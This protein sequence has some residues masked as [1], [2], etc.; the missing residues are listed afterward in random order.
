MNLL[1]NLIEQYLH[2]V[3]PSEYHIKLKDIFS[4][5]KDNQV[6]VKL[7]NDF[8]VHFS[9][10][11]KFEIHHINL[12]INQ[13]EF[14]FAI[15]TNNT[16][17]L[18]QYLYNKR[19]IY[20]EF[21]DY[22]LEKEL[23]KEQLEE[24]YKDKLTNFINSILY[25]ESLYKTS[26]FYKF[27]TDRKKKELSILLENDSNSFINSKY[28]L[29]KAFSND[30]F[31]KLD[32]F[33]GIEKSKEQFSIKAE[34][35]QSIINNLSNDYYDIANY[36]ID[37]FVFND[38]YSSYQRRNYIYAGKFLESIIYSYSLSQKIEIS[39]ETKKK[40]NEYIALN[41]KEKD[42]WSYQILK[43]LNDQVYS[44]L[45][46]KKDTHVHSS[47]KVLFEE[48]NSI[49]DIDLEDT[50]S[51]LKKI[52]KVIPFG[53]EFLHNNRY[54]EENFDD[55][56]S[57][58]NESKNNY[59]LKD[60]SR[61]I[62]IWKNVFIDKNEL[63]S[64]SLYEIIYKF[65][66][67]IEKAKFDD[68]ISKF[69]ELRDN[70]VLI[71]LQRMILMFINSVAFFENDSSEVANINIALGEKLILDTVLKNTPASFQNIKPMFEKEGSLTRALFFHPIIS[72]IL[73]PEENLK[74][75]DLKFV[76][77]KEISKNKKN[78]D[79]K[80]VFNSIF[81]K[82][83]QK[84]G[85]YKKGLPQTM[86]PIDICKNYFREIN[87][88]IDNNSKKLLTVSSSKYVST[89]NFIK[90]KVLD[91]DNE[92]ETLMKKYQDLVTK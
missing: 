53:S 62:V 26:E 45:Y 85:Y 1:N 37:L 79:K 63:N 31:R 36:I 10:I 47:N 25:K 5:L 67:N 29:Y 28:N 35:L 59:D 3:F 69:S 30:K 74:L 23:K 40:I 91:K 76:S 21:F 24:K 83:W 68:K 49:K 13:N 48:F 6:K 88:N 90:E 51:E 20:N 50:I 82:Y 64:L 87:K 14:R 65:F 32:K 12:G 7:N 38:Y 19:N 89:Y 86:N 80:E 60:L 78:I 43:N 42:K 33:N 46:D 9:E 56:S 92:L 34:G 17:E 57:D 39:K 72:H 11:E 2:K 71:Y 73:F 27:S 55:D 4:I 66:R 41:L 84:V 54:K 81:Y 61:A 70:N 52:V 22:F 75:N 16:R 77:A 8:L 58:E 18:I 15:F 44:I